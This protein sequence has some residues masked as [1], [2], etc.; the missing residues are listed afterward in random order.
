MNSITY[1]FFTLLP[2]ALS[3]GGKRCRVVQAK[4]GTY[5]IQVRG[6]GAGL[7]WNTIKKDLSESYASCYTSQLANQHNYTVCKPKLLRKKFHTHKDE[8]GLLVRCYHHSKNTLLSISFWLGVTLSFPL[9]HF[10]WT[11]VWPFA[12]ITGYFHLL[13]E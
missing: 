6:G 13:H 4:D 1:F 8:K 10:I 2:H 5:S 9:E 3:G 12:W 7:F 11:K